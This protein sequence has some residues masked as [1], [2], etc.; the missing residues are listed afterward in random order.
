MRSLVFLSSCF[1][2]LY[3]L[4]GCT[5]KPSLPERLPQAASDMVNQKHI[6]YLRQAADAGVLF[7]I[8]DNALQDRP[9][10]QVGSCKSLADPVWDDNLYSILE[11]LDQN[12]KLY[13]KFHVLRLRRGNTSQ[14]KIE[15]DS[16]GLV[17]LN[18][19]YSKR[20]SLEKVTAMTDLP[21]SA[22]TAEYVGRELE[23]TNF[24]WPSAETVASVLSGAEDKA[25]VV[26]M[27]FDRRILLYLADRMAI[28][29]TQQDHYF[30]KISNGTDMIPTVLNKL[31]A[32]VAAGSLNEVEFWMKEINV[33]SLAST[34]IVFLGLRK[35]MLGDYGVRVDSAGKYA[36]KI[37]GLSDVTYLFLSY[38]AEGNDYALTSLADLNR[39]LGNFTQMYRSSGFTKS[40]DLDRESYLFPGY[41][42]KTNP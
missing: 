15:K 2:F 41:S 34:S 19:D 17:Y 31:S 3:L 38:K 21:C 10:R 8:S 22:T 5:T 28:L 1:L 36:R 7:L 42:C 39:C 24:E 37:N 23:N 6:R 11:K 14:A 29:K 20:R 18:V 32:E 16:D 12:P 30:E 35:D 4:S 25:S 13:G 33:N 27:N 26:K 9:S 40:F